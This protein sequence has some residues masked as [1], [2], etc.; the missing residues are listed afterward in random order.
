MTRLTK[1]TIAATGLASLAACGLQG[2]LKRPD[3]LFGD[4]QSRP[5]AVLPDRQVQ[6]GTSVLQEE[7]GA[8]ARDETSQPDADDELLG[9]TD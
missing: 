8:P 4:P 1:L 5:D 2:D 3:P 7:E 9:G 6:E